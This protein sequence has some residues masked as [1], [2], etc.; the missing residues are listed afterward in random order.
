[1]SIESSRSHLITTFKLETNN[2][3]LKTITKSKISLIDL[4]G[5]ERINKSNPTYN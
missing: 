3:N 4:A 5:S 1:M 2:N